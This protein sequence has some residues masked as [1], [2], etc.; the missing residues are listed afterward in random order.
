MAKLTESPGDLTPT[1]A[2]FLVVGLGA[3][4]GGVEALREFF[5][6]VPADSGLAYV[7]ILHLSPEYDSQLATVLQTVTPIPVTPVTERVR[8]EP[9]HAY[10]VLPNQHLTM[11]DGHLTVSANTLLEERRAPI[12]MFFRTLAESHHGQAVS[13]VLSG[14]GTDGAMGLKRV[15]ERGGAVFVQN[16]RE[17]TFNEMP[18]SAIATDLVDDVLSVAAIPARLMAYQ[19]SLSTI[20]IPLDSEERPED[21]QQALRKVLSHLRIRTGHDFSNYKRPTLLRRIERRISV[22]NLPDLPA[23]A[24]FLRDSP[25]EVQA[26]LKDLLISVTNFF[27]DNDAFAALEQDI[28]PRIFHDKRSDEQVRIWVAGCATGEEAYSI[29]MLCAEHVL[30]TLDAPSVQIFATDIDEAALARARKGVY[31]ANETADVSPERLRRFFTVEDQRYQVRRE[32]RDMV[33]FATHNILKDP[34]FAHIDMVTCRNVLIYLNHTAQERVMETLHFALKPGGYLFLG[35]SESVDGAQDLYTTLNR[36]HHIFQSR[37]TPHRPLP[38]PESLPAVRA[39]QPR[40][41]P[42]VVEPNSWTRER[43]N[44]GDLQQRLLEAYAPP[45]VLV[46]QD[47]EVM[48]M[49]ERAGRYLQITGGELSN[50]LL[51]LIRPELHSELRTALYQAVQRQTN[52]DTSN[53]SI[54]IDDHTELVTIHVRPVLSHAD[55]AHGFLLIL[56]EHGAAAPTD[57]ERVVRSD[58]SIT[59]QLEDDVQRLKLQLRTSSEQ[60]EFQAEEFKATNEELQA[61]NEEL[62]ASTEEL[63]TSKEE[64]HAINEELRTV[65]QELKVK[66]EEATLHSTN[67]Q[68]LVNST[69]IGTIFLD[70]DLRVKLFT[71]S[72]RELFNLLAADYGRPLSDITHRLRNVD[73][74]ID[75]ETVLDT[76]S[77]IE[78]EVWTTDQQLFLLRVLPYRAGEDR[79][80]GVV[81]SFFD[82]TERKRAEEAMR[83]TQERLTTA[84]RTARMAAWEWDLITDQVIASDTMVDLFGLVPGERWHSSAQGFRLVHPDDLERHRAT[85]EAGR[86]EG[87]SWHSEFRII[88]PRDG[89][90]AWLEERATATREL[91]TDALRITGLVWEITERKQAEMVLAEQARLLDLSNDAIIVLNVDN[92]ITYWNHGATEMYGWTREE[93]LGQDVHQLLDAELEIPPEQ[94]VPQMDQDDRMEREIVQITRDGRRVHTL[95]RWALDR[96][97]QGRPGAILTTYYDITERKRAEAVL[98]E[99]E[100]RFRTLADAIPQLIWT[101]TAD[102]SANYFNSRWY[103]YSGLSYDESA[104]LGWQAIVHPDDAP[105]SVERWQ[106]TLAAGEVFD[107]EYRLRRTDGIYRWHLGRNVPLRDEHGQIIGWFGS[108]TDI[109]DVKQ[110]EAARRESDERFR[111]LIEGARDYAMFLLGPDYRITFWSIGAE[112]LFGWSAAEAVGQSFSMIFT[113]EDRDLGAMEGE[114]RTAVAHGRAEDRRWHVRKDGSRMFVDGVLIRLDDDQGHVRGFVKIGRDT[115]VQRK[116]ED[117]LQRAHDDLEHRIAERTAALAA[118]N[119]SLHQENAERRQLE[120]QRIALLQRIISVQED[121]RRRIARELHDTLRQ[122]LTGLNLRVSSLHGELE[123]MSQFHRGLSDLSQLARDIDKELD[124]LTM[125]LRPS[126]LD[127]LGL[128]QALHTYVE[129]WSA[130]SGIAVDVLVQGLGAARLSATL[131]TTIYRI[132]QE[133]LTNVVRH[134][135][136]TQVSVLLERRGE[137]LQMIVEDNGQGFNAEAE[138]QDSSEGQYLGLLGMAERAMLVGGTLTIDS[139]PGG[140]TTIFLHIPLQHESQ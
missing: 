26:L 45:S 120:A 78:R 123:D 46:N 14:S 125:E 93:A 90:I 69:N 49:S 61:L 37:Y 106:H 16:P 89:Q 108:A 86:R 100:A 136:A 33:L 54:R 42:I 65:N 127:D 131:E 70:R 94:L 104:G 50:N 41:A 71:P 62:R 34:P 23:Y 92:Q 48:R 64:L 63:E 32:L 139:A 12:D 87:G 133:A 105:A 96:N 52:V 112:R 58:D 43:I 17:A 82:I 91:E 39:D 73:V 11:D 51:N 85:V 77:M 124:R 97:E 24:V 44:Y 22:S 20:T 137:Q 38:V 67:L 72:A 98:R 117:D 83:K 56:F 135:Q 19:A 118:A 66:I 2:G 109:E 128:E 110:A 36:E 75:A 111:L 4:A 10:V 9:N 28:L 47:Y 8:V 55:P 18:R 102:G 80:G 81:I 95:C 40:V 134:A 84:L 101:N 138:R 116:A 53:L 7:V 79:I 76:L 13:V 114:V 88:R 68:N 29:A 21:Q 132:V 121:E 30:D 103:D 74:L 5:R 31:T 3:S 1:H 122:F 113:P 60:Y 129:Q 15:K 25:D 6:H 59:H 130:T 107:T 35:T 126:A 115:T 119:R 57:A 99:N 140:G 27:R